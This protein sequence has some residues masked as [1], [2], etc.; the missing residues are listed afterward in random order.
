M[1][2][3]DTQVISC[4]NMVASIITNLNINSVHPAAI[5][6]KNRKLEGKIMQDL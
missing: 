3:T 2:L 5:A 6:E 1:A 4:L